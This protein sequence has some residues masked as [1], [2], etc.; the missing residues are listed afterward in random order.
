MNS[1]V[2][3]Q[4]YFSQNKLIDSC[5]I[6]YVALCYIK[7]TISSIKRISMSVQYILWL[8]VNVY[9]IRVETN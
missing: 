9:I 6:Y 8:N 7:L 2:S 5:L 4:I 1:S 3:R